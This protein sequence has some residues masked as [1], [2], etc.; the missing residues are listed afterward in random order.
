MK[1]TKMNW[2]T[3]R[4]NQWRMN[5]WLTNLNAGME[6][7]AALRK[8]WLKPEKALGIL[9]Y[10]LNGQLSTVG[11]LT[12]S[13][14]KFSSKMNQGQ[15]ALVMKSMVD[16]LPC[17]PETEQQRVKEKIEKLRDHNWGYV[18]SAAEYALA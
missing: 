9:E 4:F 8:A 6:N 16:L 18:R 12:F 2:I 14:G 5:R 15:L 7:S 10:V 13:G 3:S 1:G 11:I 17:L